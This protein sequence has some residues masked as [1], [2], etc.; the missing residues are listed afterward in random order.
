MPYT[1]KHSR[2][3]RIN[4][5]DNR[6]CG[7]PI[8][9]GSAS[10]ATNFLV[11]FKRNHRYSGTPF[12][13]NKKSPAYQCNLIKYKPEPEPEPEPES[14]PEQGS[15]GSLGSVGGYPWQNDE[16]GEPEPEPEPE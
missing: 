7:G 8:K 16:E 3:S 13:D 14:E 12:Y 5:I 15:L 6:S 1:K 2:S 11:G 10:R 9:A 4:Y